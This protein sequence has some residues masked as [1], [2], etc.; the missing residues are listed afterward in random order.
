MQLSEPGCLFRRVKSL[1]LNQGHQ[2]LEPPIPLQSGGGAADVSYKAAPAA[3]VA[4]IAKSNHE[5]NLLC[6]DR[7]SLTEACHNYTHSDIV[8]K[9][10]Q[11]R[12]NLPV[13]DAAGRQA[14]I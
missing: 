5:F 9:V 7:H 11:N 6:A 14:G 13:S 8:H 4:V 1:L 10:M 12:S 3:A 2:D